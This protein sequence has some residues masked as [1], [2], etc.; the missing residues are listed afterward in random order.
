M[1]TIQSTYTED[2]QQA[3]AGMIASTSTCDVDSFVYTVNDNVAFGR[4]MRATS[5][6]VSGSPGC[7]GYTADDQDNDGSEYIG[8]G[9]IDRTLQP[10][11][12]DQY[13]RGDVVSVA[14][15]GDVW[16][17]VEAAVTAGGAVSF[18]PH[19]GQF[20]SKAASAT[21]GSEQVVLSD[22]RWLTSQSTANGLAI[23]RMGASPAKATS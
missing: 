4:A 6:D 8:I 11:Q 20:S 21:D 18:N 17:S 23:L 9:V 14:I 16:V 10:T 12:N 7:A 19:N 1:A 13:G 5:T 22:Y 3:Y 2:H 15:R